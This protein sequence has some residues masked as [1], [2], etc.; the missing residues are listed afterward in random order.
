MKNR[1]ILLLGIG[2]LIVLC[3]GF[4]F[5]LKR[6]SLIFSYI[7]LRDRCF[8]SI[9]YEP[10]YEDYG[11]YDIHDFTIGFANFKNVFGKIDEIKVGLDSSNIFLVTANYK[12]LFLWPLEIESCNELVP[13]PKNNFNF[14]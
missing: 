3:V 2:I 12:I 6:A 7:C 10:T 4:F 5:F 9:S 1:K 13:F 8:E 11:F 14:F